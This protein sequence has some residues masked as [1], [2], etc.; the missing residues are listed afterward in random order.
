MNAYAMLMPLST[1]EVDKLLISEYQ[2]I[3]HIFLITKSS[4]NVR[5]GVVYQK[6]YRAGYDVADKGIKNKANT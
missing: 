3:F 2:P 1:I 6:A 5:D 4:L